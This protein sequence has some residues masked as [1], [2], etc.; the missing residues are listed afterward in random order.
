V[1]DAWTEEKNASLFSTVGSNSIRA[2]INVV[3]G[4]PL[5][6]IAVSCYVTVQFSLT[7]RHPLDTSRATVALWTTNFT[8]TSGRVVLRY[9][10]A[11]GWNSDWH[12]GI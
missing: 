11:W 8:V 3:S 6:L 1:L 5:H 7:G 10:M 9:P 4:T 2:K 12:L